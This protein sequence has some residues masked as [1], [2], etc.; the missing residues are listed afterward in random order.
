MTTDFRTE[1]SGLFAAL[2]GTGVRYLLVG[3]VAMLS[4]VE[5][6]NTEDID[7]IVNP[8]DI[9][10]LPFSATSRD[11]DFGSGSYHGVRIDLLLTSNLLF[12]R[13]LRDEKTSVEIEGRQVAVCS[14]RGLVLLKLFALPSLYRQGNT[15]RAAL[16]ETDVFMLLQKCDVAND[17]VLEALK[18]HLSATDLGEIRAILEELRAR[19]RR[20]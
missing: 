14:A 7:L 20:F 17:W 4:Y 18:P 6:R 13:V 5:G 2:E 3:G 11:G 15:A 16:Y 10:S 9:A 8:A 1:V 19:R 12:D